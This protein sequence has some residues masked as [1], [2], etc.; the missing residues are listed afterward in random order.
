LKINVCGFQ[1]KAR[2][3]F[4]LYINGK[5]QRVEIKSPDSNCNTYSNWGIVKPGVPQG[6]VLSPVLFLIYQ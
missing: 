4:K 6:S 5:K 2:Q 3:W 1:G